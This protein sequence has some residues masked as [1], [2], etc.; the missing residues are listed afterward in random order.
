MRPPR[1][2]LQTDAAV[3]QPFAAVSAAPGC[4]TVPSRAPFQGAGEK[5]GARRNPRPSGVFRACVS[6]GAHR[7]P[8]TLALAL[9]ALLALAAAP[10]RAGA[11]P[12][13]PGPPR[14]P[15]P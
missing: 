14:A 11:P 10:A 15:P 6:H 4:H 5:F 13:T 2:P 3:L 8:V 1:L 7:R 9:A 12:S